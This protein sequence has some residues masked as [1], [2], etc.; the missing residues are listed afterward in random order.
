MNWKE[1]IDYDGLYMISDTGLVKSM[2]RLKRN[3]NNS[4]YTKEKI[5]NAG[6]SKAGYK[7]V[8][9]FKNGK[10][11]TRYVHHLVAESFLNHKVEGYRK[12]IDHIDENKTNNNKD[13]LQIV[14]NRKNIR[15]GFKNTYSK[16]IG[17]TY[18]KTNKRYLSRIRIDGKQIN[19]GSFKNENDASI[20]YQQKLKEY[21]NIL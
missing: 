4:Y 3:A 2:P 11:E 12:V 8:V 14:S 19:L 5:L 21:E 13:N 20:A 17:V 10:R 7:S 1:V 16:L 9:L 15:K 18:D 6:Y